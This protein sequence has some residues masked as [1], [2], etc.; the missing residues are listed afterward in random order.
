MSDSSIKN[1]EQFAAISGISRPTISKY[2]N[3]PDS[4][5]RSS[6]ERIEAAIEKYNYRPNIFAMNQNRAM[7]KN[8]GIVVPLLSD[9][10]F[11]E[12]ARNLE[13]HCIDAGYR[14]T[15]FSSHGD[16]K[17]EV[18]ILDNLRSLTPAGVLF[19]PLGRASNRDV[20]EKFCEDVPTL[21]FDSNVGE[22]GIEF[23]GSDNMQ[24]AR[25]ITNYLCRSGEPPC[26]FEMK[27][28]ANPNAHRRRQSYIA[29]MTAFGFEPQVISVD[30]EGWAFE[31]IG[32]RGANDALARKLFSTN[33]VL[34]SNDRLAIGFLAACYENGL[35][36]GRSEGDAIRVAGQDGH[37]LTRYSC[38][39]LT[40]ISHNYEAVS[41]Q[42]AQALFAA[43]DGQN[44]PWKSTRIEG[45]LILRAS[46]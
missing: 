10:Y 23:V 19:A 37:R 7:T 8:I 13:Q 27:T 42:A 45:K 33:T 12:I 40:T 3:D 28:P 26:F 11:A 30:G 6:R 39:S 41:L 18:E 15:M 36:V 1:M 5:R 44:Q 46:A 21:I 9:T 20:L 32:F 16:P 34:C 2:F 38:P 22:I 24:F 43:I 14:P 31:E 4:V 35:S 29:A 25:D 17:F